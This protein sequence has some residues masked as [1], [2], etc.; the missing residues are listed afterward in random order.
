M[1]KHGVRFTAANQPIVYWADD[2]AQLPP[3]YEGSAAAPRAADGEADG[4]GIGMRY[5][6]QDDFQPSPPPSP[7]TAA[8]QAATS[9]GVTPA[10][11][12]GTTTPRAPPAPKP[13]AY[14]GFTPPADELDG[15]AGMRMRRAR[16][17][18]GAFAMQ[19]GDG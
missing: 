9:G 4:D 18:R 13:K 1:K 8:A 3:T 17:K 2:A 16:T 15:T 11:T 12:S 14:M 6:L 19:G 5:T 7:T 10:A